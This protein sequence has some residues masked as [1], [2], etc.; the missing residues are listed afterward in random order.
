MRTIADI[1][2]AARNRSRSDRTSTT[3]RISATRLSRPSAP[4]FPGE[5]RQRSGGRQCTFHEDR[6]GWRCRIEVRLSRRKH[7]E[8]P[9]WDLTRDV[10]LR[11]YTEDKP[12]IQ[13][14]EYSKAM[15]LN[16]HRDIKLAS[17][18]SSS[19]L[20]PPAADI[21]L[22]KLKTRCSAKPVSQA[23]HCLKEFKLGTI[24]ALNSCRTASRKQRQA[25]GRSRPLPAC[26]KVLPDMISTGQC[27]YVNTPRE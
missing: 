1:R 18:P 17:N 24:R 20:A 27:R 6:D 5:R 2:D 3:R 7:C 21:C 4:S 23:P 14:Q 16:Q 9:A 25:G 26:A 15:A 10:S 19:A 12:R 11:D 8:N 13:A 22:G